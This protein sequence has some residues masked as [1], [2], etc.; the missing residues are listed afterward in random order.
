[1]E[2]KKGSSPDRMGS[3]NPCGHAFRSWIGL[4][5]CFYR[6]FFPFIRTRGIAD[7]SGV[8]H[9]GVI[10]TW[11]IHKIVAKNTYLSENMIG[12]IDKSCGK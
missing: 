3:M 9:H 8:M 6:T 7:F 2:F 12:A 1:M 11:I 10:L 5:G 4:Q